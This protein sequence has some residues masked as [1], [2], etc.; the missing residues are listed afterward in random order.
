MREG[1][2]GWH[3]VLSATE[4]TRPIEG[5]AIAAVTQLFAF[6]EGSPHAFLQPAPTGRPIRTHALDAK[7]H[8]GG[9]TVAGAGIAPI[10]G[11]DGIAKQ[12]AI[13]RAV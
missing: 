12:Q 5:S 11:D 7:N 4:T 9:L 1:A 6:G 13:T 8:P 2:E 3:V 10:E